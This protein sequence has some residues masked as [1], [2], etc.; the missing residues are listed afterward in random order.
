M[1]ADLSDKKANFISRTV[2]AFVALAE[3][4]DALVAL[5]GEWDASTYSTAIVDGDCTG[6]N[7]HLTATI[8]AAAFVSQGNL[9]TY[10]TAG[11]N[12]NIEA[13]RP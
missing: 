7:K 5:R 8:L 12:T 2:T 1:A 10:W 9:E 3:A 6:A 11:N 4:R 13:M